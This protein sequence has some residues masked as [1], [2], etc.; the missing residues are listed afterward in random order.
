MEHHG[1]DGTIHPSAH[2]HQYPSF[3]AHDVNQ[4]RKDTA[5][6][7]TLCFAPVILSLTYSAGC[8]HAGNNFQKKFLL[9]KKGA[10][11]ADPKHGTLAQLVE[12]RTENPCVAGSIPAGTTN[13]KP[14]IT[15]RLFCLLPNPGFSAACSDIQS[16]WAGRHALGRQSIPQVFD[17]PY[18]HRQLCS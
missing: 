6:F 10:T 5:I 4:R 8:L 14:H 17:W 13:K 7:Q 16:S 18:R 15:V 2:G 3:F 9:I 12:Q 1:S 11:F